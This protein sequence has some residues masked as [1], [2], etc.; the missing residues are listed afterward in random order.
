MKVRK[1]VQDVLLASDLFPGTIE[2]VPDYQLLYCHVH[3]QPVLYTQLDSHLYRENWL[4]IHL[5]RPLVE[6]CATL[7]TIANS[8]EI[9]PRANHSPVLSI[10]PLQP[11]AY[12]CNTAGS[13]L[14][15]GSNQQSF[16]HCSF[17][18]PLCLSNKL[19][20]GHGPELVSSG[21][22]SQVLDCVY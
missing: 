1:P 22:T 21:H 19:S 17:D 5:R 7:E 20:A 2:Y 9:L 14:L 10:L 11:G 15:V 6:H 18:L 4:D 3:K 8:G 13:L 12:S 16:G